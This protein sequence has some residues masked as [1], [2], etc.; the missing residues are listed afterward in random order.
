MEMTFEE[1]SALHE[2]WC[3]E[4]ERGES[5]EFARALIGRY[6][7]LAPRNRCTRETV[8]FSDGHD[9]TEL[10]AMPIGWR[11]A[12]GL[13]MV[14]DLRTVLLAIGGEEALHSYTIDQI[15]EKYGELRWYTS[16]PEDVSAEAADWLNCVEKLYCSICGYTCIFC[17]RMDD[18]RVTSGWIVPICRNEKGFESAK[19]LPKLEANEP[20]CVCTRYLPDGKRERQDYK[21][22]CVGK[23]APVVKALGLSNPLLVTNVWQR[24]CGLDHDSAQSSR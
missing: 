16:G 22:L 2:A 7:F 8:E 20:F 3:Q 9:R 12:I 1:V 14:E 23:N 6:P 19:E 15:K 24:L 13:E 11:R 17:G 10:S 4:G 18:V 21:E 5:T